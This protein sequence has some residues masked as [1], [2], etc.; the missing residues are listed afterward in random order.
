[1]A[2]SEA[3]QYGES[4]NDPYDLV[5]AMRDVW[6]ISVLVSQAFI[7]LFF[8]LETTLSMGV[9]I[10]K[11][12]IDL[13]FNVPKKSRNDMFK[14]RSGYG[15]SCP[16]GIP[17]EFGLLSI[18]AAFGV[19]FGV[20]YMALTIITGRRKKRSL[21]DEEEGSCEAS[22]IQGYYGCHLQNFMSG[23][24]SSVWFHLADVLWHGESGSK[25]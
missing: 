10:R 12:K 17:V 3:R 18:L 1:M 7:A 6:N 19:A 5:G 24:E 25:K 21:E 15:G 20:L 23:H 14:H 9:G 8:P 2:E 22:S 13:M 11:I 16:E 4:G